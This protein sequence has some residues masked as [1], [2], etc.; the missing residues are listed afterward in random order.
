MSGLEKCL[1][2]IY[3]VRFREIIR[4]EI[5]TGEKSNV[6]FLSETTTMT[7]IK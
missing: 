1:A 7:T 6:F 4:C 3:N 5:Y 2:K